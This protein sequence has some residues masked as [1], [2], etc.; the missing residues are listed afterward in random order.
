MKIKNMAY[1]L[2]VGIAIVIILIYGKN[3]ILPLVLAILIWFLIKGIRNGIK[4]IKIRNRI[5]PLWL[6]NILAFIIV[7]G[8]L[9]FVG[10]LLANN[11]NKISALLPLYEANIQQMIKQLNDYTGL[12]IY[13]T[14]NNYIGDFDFSTILK[15]LLNSITDLFGSAF[16]VIIYVVFLLLEEAIFS[17]KIKAVFKEQDQFEK[18]NGILQKVNKSINSYIT[19]KTMVSL[20]TGSV[21]YIVLLI[22]HIDFAFF[23]AF[24]IFVLNYIPTIGSLIATLFPSIIAL[25]Q[26][27]SF[28]HFFLVLALIGAV[29][30][31]VGNLLEPR[32]MGQTLNISPLVVIISLTFWGAIW[33]VLGMLL[34]VPIMVMLIIIFAQFENTKSIAVLLSAKGNV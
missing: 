24:L 5:A 15:S 2:V 29:Q 7:F 6:Q 25:V 3:I 33:G 27:S 20:I 21:S 1:A 19:L 12:D 18:V 4:R 28:S 16:I 17:L 9:T 31:L 32:I 26:F 11:I 14:L 23:W 10:K 22:L 30:I 8:I 34:S 13:A